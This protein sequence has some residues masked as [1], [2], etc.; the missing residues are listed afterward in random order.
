MVIDDVGIDCLSDTAIPRLVPWHMAS[1]LTASLLRALL[2]CFLFSVFP[3]SGAL[4][5]AIN[6]YQPLSALVSGPSTYVGTYIKSRTSTLLWSFV[7]SLLHRLYLQLLLYLVPIHILLPLH[8]LRLLFLYPLRYAFS[9]QTPLAALPSRI[10]PSSSPL[11]FYL[12][13]ELNQQRLYSQRI[14]LGFTSPG[15]C[16][17]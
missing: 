5:I 15:L 14:S 10:P 8:I 13:G 7:S 12:H 3:F 9:T 2:P 16:Q 17:R 1:T 6:R 4:S 11:Y